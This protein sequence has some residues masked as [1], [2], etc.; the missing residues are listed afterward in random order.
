MEIFMK[1]SMYKKFAI[2]LVGLTLSI[3]INTALVTAHCDTMDGPVVADAKTAFEK[4]NVNYVLKW[5]K[6]EYEN[7]IKTAFMQVMKVRALSAEAKDLSEKYFYD[8]LVRL[9]RAGEGVPFTGVKPS[10][11]PVDEKIKAADISIEKS[12][13]I[14]VEKIV[15]KDGLAHAKELFDRV[16]KLK[17]FNIENVKAGREYVEAYVQYFHFIEGGKETHAHET[18]EHTDEKHADHSTHLDHIVR[19]LSV[20]FFLTTILFGVL[21]KKARRT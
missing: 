8:L 15:P 11:T 21:Y 19:I 14:I 6:S 12:D 10:G 5:V 18:G 4:N 3:L 2:T 20:V 17:N 16:I 13:F 9:H 1:T 7:E